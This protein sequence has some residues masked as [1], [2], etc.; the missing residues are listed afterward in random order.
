MDLLNLPIAITDSILNRKDVFPSPPWVVEILIENANIT[1]DCL[2]LEPSAGAGNLALE[3]QNLGAMVE[4][5]EP[6]PELQLV[7]T[8]QNLLVIGSDF[9]TTP[10]LEGKYDRI[11]QN[12]PFSL[13][14]SHTI[15]AYRCLK[16]G[17]RLV[18]LCSSSPWQHNSNLDKYF[19]NWLKT[20]GAQAIDLPYGLFVNSVRYTDVAC[21]LIIIEKAN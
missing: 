21:H 19:R 10:S 12:P 1:P 5:I 13:Q 16:P 7:L 20:V 18:S 6:I 14:V 3:L 4:V 15:K 17:G 2:C 8:L 11:I 9:L